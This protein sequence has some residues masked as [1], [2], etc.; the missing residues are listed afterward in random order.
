MERG[1]QLDRSSPTTC[2]RT[3]WRSPE[4]VKR[5]SR[6][7]E[8]ESAVSTETP[9]PLF[10]SVGAS[11]PLM[12]AG[13]RP[14]S[15]ERAPHKRLMLFGGRSNPALC[16]RIADHLGVNLGEVTLK[17]FTNSEVYARYEESVRGAD[18]FIVQSCSPNA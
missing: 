18:V 11:A 17:T 6:D 2:R 5:T 9:I 7:M 12:T 8:S 16:E 4:P 15:V 3:R 10:S 13:A 14:T 1:R